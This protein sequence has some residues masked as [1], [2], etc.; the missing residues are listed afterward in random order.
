ML[1]LNDKRAL[2]RDS[3]SIVGTQADHHRSELVRHREAAH[4]FTTVVE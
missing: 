2:R 1:F 4:H 3:L